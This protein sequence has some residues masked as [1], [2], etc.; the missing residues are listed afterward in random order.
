[1]K[2]LVSWIRELG[3][4]VSREF[5]FVMRDLM[6]VHGWRHVE[7]WVLAQCSESPEE[8]LIELCGEVPE[9]VLFWETYDLVNA[10]APAM[11]HLGCKMQLFADDLHLLWN[12][13]Q[14]REAR[15]RALAAC[16]RVLTPYAYVFDSFY[17]E[18]RGKKDV[19][20]IPH[21]A[22]PD[23]FLDLNENP[24]PRILLSGFVGAPYPLRSRMKQLSDEGWESIVHLVHPGYGENFDHATDKRVGPGYAAEIHKYLIGFSDAAVY[25]Y[26]V[27]KHFEIPATGALLV[28]DRVIRDPLERLGFKEREHYIGASLD[29][30]ID[31]IHYVLDNANREEV[32]SIRR[33]GQALVLAA[34]RTSHRACLIDAQ[35]CAGQAAAGAQ[36]SHLQPWAYDGIAVST[37]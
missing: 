10:I 30:L 37:P 26:V 9:V 33:N 2:L 27:A 29:S 36:D 19:V 25:R 35:A 3:R 6:E 31:T 22:S 4:Y 1:M 24:Q 5:H 34:H 18:L 23:F 20:W 11:R 12:E 17:P 8:K 32:D 13:E 7:P 21:A 16:D 15:L 28:T 14:V